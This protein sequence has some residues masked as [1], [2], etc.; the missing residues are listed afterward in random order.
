MKSNFDQVF[1]LVKDLP[2]DGKLE[3]Q[4]KYMEV[5]TKILPSPVAL[6]I[7]ESLKELRGINKKK[8]ESLKSE[9]DSKQIVYNPN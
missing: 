3:T 7:Y 1:D 5:V 4:I 2:I 9:Q 6:G 8:V